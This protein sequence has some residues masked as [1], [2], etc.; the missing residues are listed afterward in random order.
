M[1]DLKYRG[2]ETFRNSG[3]GDNSRCVCHKPTSDGGL[4]GGGE[5]LGPGQLH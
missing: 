1:H 2:S 4:D 5:G 3:Q